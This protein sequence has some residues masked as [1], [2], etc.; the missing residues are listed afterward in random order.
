MQAMKTRM[1]PKRLVTGIY[2]GDR[3]RNLVRV[4]LLAI[5]D[6]GAAGNVAEAIGEMYFNLEP[7]FNSL[8]REIL[9]R[10]ANALGD[11]F[12]SALGAGCLEAS[13][14]VLRADLVTQLRPG[15]LPETSD[16]QQ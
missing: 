8:P 12:N 15:T 13:E 6:D 4:G 16:T 14:V 10:V 11:L 5:N 3:N 7:D 1:L 2:I 9:A